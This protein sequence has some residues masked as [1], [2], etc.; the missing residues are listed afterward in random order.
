MVSFQSV[1]AI[2]FFI[3]MFCF[4]FYKRKKLGVQKVL[5]PLI[6]VLMYRTRLGLDSMDKVARKFPYL[7]YIITAGIVVGFLGMGFICFELI[8]NSVKLFVSPEAAAS[9]QPVLPFEAKGV[10]FVPFIYWILSIFIIATVHEFCHGV[11]ARFFDFRVKSSG[12]AFLCLFFPVIPAA[13]VEPDDKQLAKAGLRNKMGV[14]AAGP[15]SNILTAG[16]ILLLV[17]AVFNPVANVLFMPAGIK[18]VSVN[19]DGPS[20]SSGMAPDDIIT[21]VNGVFVHDVGAFVNELK[22][23]SPGESISLKT[24]KG[25]RMITLGKNPSDESLPWLG[26]SSR[27]H[28]IIRE[29]IKQSIGEFIPQA[30]EWVFG[31]FYWLFLLSLGIGLFNLLPMGPLDGGLMLRGIL[32]RYYG[33]NGIFVFRLVSW[34]FFLLILI[35]LGVGFIR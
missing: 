1:L 18:V 35:N 22:V 5:F 15:F 9:V 8:R 7:G 34:G 29:N 30:V 20:F 19:E 2:V 31:F 24:D 23:H 25:V 11:A 10:F 27:P 17:L 3:V 28:S 21:D 14:F 12:F 16:I 33:Q 13:F 26:I 6:Y 32:Q 4:L